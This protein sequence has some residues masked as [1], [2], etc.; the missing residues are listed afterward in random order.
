MIRSIM[1]F[2]LDFQLKK[3]QKLL[4]SVDIT[5]PQSCESGAAAAASA[6]LA[7]DDRSSPPQLSVIIGVI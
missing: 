3:N 4:Y 6:L 1:F 7:R 2:P 5:F